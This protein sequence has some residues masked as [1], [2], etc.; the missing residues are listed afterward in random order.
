MP[1]DEGD[2]AYLWDMLQ[3]ANEMQGMLEGHDLTSFLGDCVLLRAIERSVEIIDE[4][5]HRVS[6][7]YQQD[8]PEIP[9]REIICQRN[10]LV[11]EYGQIDHPLLYKIAVEDIPELNCRL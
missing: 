8:H 10:I 5:A 2:L 3:A 9:W 1:P 7:S 6:V 11:H 4:A